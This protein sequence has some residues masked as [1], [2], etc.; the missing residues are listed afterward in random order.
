M[1]AENFLIDELQNGK[2]K[3]AILQNLMVVASNLQGQECKRKY[4]NYTRKREKFTDQS[5][6]ANRRKAMVSQNWMT[7]MMPLR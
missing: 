7:D 1:K 2:G 6:E 3:R 5:D 4:A